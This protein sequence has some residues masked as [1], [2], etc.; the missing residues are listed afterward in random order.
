MVNRGLGRGCLVHRVARAASRESRVRES[1]VRESR[2]QRGV[3]R[4]GGTVAAGCEVPRV[5]EGK[6]G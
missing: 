3:C 2:V 1:C 6:T 4:T 5:I